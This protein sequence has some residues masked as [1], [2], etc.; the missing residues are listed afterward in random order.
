VSKVYFDVRDI[1]KALRLG[2]SGKKMALGFVGVVLGYVG[3]AILAYLA[4]LAGGYPFGEIWGSY[5]FYPCVAGLSL[6]WYSWVIYGVGVVFWMLVLLA[7]AAGIVKIAYRQLKGDEFY[8]LGDAR[9]FLRK[10]WKAAVVSPWIILAVFAF[11]IA[12]GIVIGIIGRIP[13]F[14]ELFV[15]VFLFLI[16]PGSLF[17]VFTAVVFAFSLMLSPAVVG[18]AEEDTLETIVQSFS[19]VWNQPWRLVL[20]EVLL[21]IYVVLTTALLGAFTIAALW[22]VHWICGLLMGDSMV[23]LTSVAL[24]YL[25]HFGFWSALW[26]K[27]GWLPLRE[28]AEITRATVQV[29]GVIAGIWLALILGFVLSYGWTSW[30]VGQGVIYL[31]LRYKK[32]QENLLER[33][34]REEEEVKEE[35]K[36]E[37]KEAEKEEKTEEKKEEEGKEGTEGSS[38]ES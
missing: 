33:K 1:A 17:A 29:S 34:E 14:G 5:K 9:K 31:V 2:F 19:T 15:S 18:T 35:V 20:Y 36:E 4:L 25:P 23:K 38:S 22:L 3:Y 8:S 37:A 16:F 24:G 12:V 10:N 27:L 13:Y 32:D 11:L 21:G 28:G 30:T 26:T 7:T 6:P